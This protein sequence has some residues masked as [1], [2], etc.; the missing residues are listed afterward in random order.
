MIKTHKSMEIVEMQIK[1]GATG[2]LCGTLDEA[3][4]CCQKGVKR[5]C[6]P[7]LW[8]VKKILKELLK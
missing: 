4:A 1:E 5:L 3:E 8:Q 2:V 7:I 6:M